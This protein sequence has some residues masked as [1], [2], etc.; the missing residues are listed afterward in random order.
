[1]KKEV[2][3]KINGIQK[4]EEETDNIELLTTGTYYKKGENYYI[5][6]TESETTGFNGAKT[7]LKLEDGNRVTMLRSKPH[8]SH[9]IIERGRRHQCLYGSLYGDM[10]IG[11]SGG[12]IT[13]TLDENGGNLSFCY[14]LDINTVLAS[15]NEVKISIR[16]V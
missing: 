14:S 10:M 2:L 16:S 12:D 6:Y 13:S 5:T 7:T 3:I 4:V 9:L 11:V 8:K 15:E 1:M